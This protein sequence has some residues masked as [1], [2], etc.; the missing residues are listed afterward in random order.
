MHTQITY[1]VV[2]Q[3]IGEKIGYE[4]SEEEIAA[5]MDDYYGSGYYDYYKETVP[6]STLLKPVINELT[7]KKLAENARRLPMEEE[8]PSAAD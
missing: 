1:D 8:N 5:Y 3:A 6:R 2:M 7:L 4:P